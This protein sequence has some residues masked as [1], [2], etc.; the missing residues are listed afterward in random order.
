M[1]ETHERMFWL[2]SFMARRVHP[3]AAR[4]NQHVK[5]LEASVV[6]GKNFGWIGACRTN[7]AVTN[8]LF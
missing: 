8:C 2:V 6:R 1:S 5:V 3:V 4:E 7:P